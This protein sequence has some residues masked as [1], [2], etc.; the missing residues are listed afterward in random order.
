[1]GDISIDS[2]YMSQPDMGY[3]STRYGICLNQIW[4]MSQ[5][6]MG[7]VSTRYG[8][9]LNQIWDMSQPDMGYVW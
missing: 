7:Y 1:M 5:P 9:C 3:V 8:I 4:D 6:D 2:C